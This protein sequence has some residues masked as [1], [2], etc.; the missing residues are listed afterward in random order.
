MGIDAIQL[1]A[2]LRGHTSIAD[3]ARASLR[4]WGRLGRASARPNTGQ[5]DAEISA[6]AADALSRAPRIFTTNDL[7]GCLPVDRYRQRAQ[8]ILDHRIEIFGREQFLGSDIDWHLDLLENGDPKGPWELGR[9]AHLQELACASRLCPSL[10]ADARAEIVA[11]IESF[12]DQTRS[13]EGLHGSASLEVAVRNIS[14]LLTLELAGGASRFPRPFVERIGRRMVDDGWFLAQH[15]EDRGVV[16]GNHLIGDLAG[17]YLLGVALDGAPGGDHFRRLARTRLSREASRQILADGAHFEGSTSYHR[18]TLELLLLA[19]LYARAR[20][21]SLG[22]SSLLHRMFVVLRG[23]LTSAGEDPR[24]GDGDDAR[25]LTMVPRSPHEHAPLTV[26]GALLFDDP[27]LAASLDGEEAL[28]IFGRLPTA[29]PSNPS[30]AAR[31]VQGGL[32]ILRS[33]RWYVAMRSGSYGQKGIGG[34]AHN[35]QLS[36]VANLDGAPLIVD[37]GTGSYSGDP[38]LRN[39]L[40]GTG[41]HSTAILGG[42]EQSPIHFERL[43]ALPDRAGGRML[44]LEDLGNR[45]LISAEHGGYL[46]LPSKVTH[47]RRVC[48]DRDLEQIKIIDEFDGV[49]IEAVEIRFHLAGPTF[50][51]YSANLLKQN[52]LFG[53]R[54]VACTG[55]ILLTQS[56]LEIHSKKS[57]RSAVYGQSS[58]GSLVRLCGVLRLPARVECWLIPQEGIAVGDDIRS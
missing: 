26:L 53:A 31:F 17:L 29:P 25:V 33:P 50:P 16:P 28:W 11:Q 21:E 3:V 14:W 41:A 35:D 5:A 8:A 4:R 57:V 42:Q 51:L 40:R 10:A 43:F 22:I 12:L 48:L 58:L 1:S 44:A 56:P 49:G 32:Q 9:M 13:G 7:S 52:E 18:F 23:Q 38:L 20:N 36:I 37:G 45:A 24:F 54:G 46:R 27:D 39:L 2:L 15:L 30:S 47:R 55:A 34:H 6:A 19:E